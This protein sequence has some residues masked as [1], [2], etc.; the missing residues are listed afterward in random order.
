MN[1]NPQNVQD[2]QKMYDTFKAF[3]DQTLDSARGSKARSYLAYYNDLMNWC[4]RRGAVENLT[5]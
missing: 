2:A 1:N 5:Q 4:V 3:Y